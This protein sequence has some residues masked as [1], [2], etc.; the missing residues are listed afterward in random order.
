MVLS[1][2][3]NLTYYCKAKKLTQRQTRWSLY[4]TEFDV[5][6]VHTPRS[7]IVESDT[8]SQQP[9]LCPEE[10]NNNEDIIMLP[11]SM[12]LNLIDT[13]LQEKIAQ[14]DDLI[15]KLWTPSNSF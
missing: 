9:D 14:S 1:D 13:A 6:L 15:N 3:K 5:K 11:D 7:K 4:L 8:L 10:D 2:H 12:F